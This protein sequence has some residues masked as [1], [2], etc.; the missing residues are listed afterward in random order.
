MNK[1]FSQGWLDLL[2]IQYHTKH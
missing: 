1:F 2:H